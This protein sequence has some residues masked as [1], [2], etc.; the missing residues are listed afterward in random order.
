MGTSE[1]IVCGWIADLLPPVCGLKNGKY[2][3]YSS[4]FQTLPANKISR[5]Q[6]LPIYSELPLLS[7]NQEAPAVQSHR[8]GFSFTCQKPFASR[9]SLR[10]IP[11][12]GVAL[13][14]NSLRSQSVPL[15]LPMGEVPRRG[16]EGLFY[17]LSHFV[18]APPEW[19]PRG[20]RGG[21]LP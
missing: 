10:T 20:E 5:S 1:Q 15:P 7:E 11:Q 21:H 3:Q 18:T 14:K 12:D 6:L 8:R 17:P 9:M 4:I 2:I 16:G 13:S 19:E